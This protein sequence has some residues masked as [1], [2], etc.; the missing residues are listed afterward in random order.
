[1]DA[2]RQFPNIYVK[3]GDQSGLQTPC[4]QESR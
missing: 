2:P 1:M 3:G 4:R